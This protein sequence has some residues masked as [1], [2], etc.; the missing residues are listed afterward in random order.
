[1]YPALIQHRR[2]RI[3]ARRYIQQQI[4][5]IVI[6]PH[7][8]I[9]K[10]SSVFARASAHDSDIIQRN[11][12]SKRKTFGKNVAFAGS[13][14]NR[15]VNVKIYLFREVAVLILYVRSNERRD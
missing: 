5:G 14:T 15:N 3:N 10:K 7:L 9:S 13:S 12:N 6:Y 4:K 8:T 2:F 11:D 1:M